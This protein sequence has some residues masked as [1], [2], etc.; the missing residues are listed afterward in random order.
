[1]RLRIPSWLN[2]FRYLQCDLRFRLPL[3]S[4]HIIQKYL[5]DMGTGITDVNGG[6]HDFL[7]PSSDEFQKLWYCSGLE[8]ESTKSEGG[9]NKAFLIEVWL[10]CLKPLSTMFQFYWCRKLEYMEKTT[11][12]PK[13][14]DKLYPIMLYWVHLAL[15]GIQTLNV[16]GDRHW[17]HR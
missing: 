17:F 5:T 9:V 3:K 14:T 13:I 6:P 16:S 1:M 10:W 7:S 12:L 2:L 4:K 8:D 15:R 11:D